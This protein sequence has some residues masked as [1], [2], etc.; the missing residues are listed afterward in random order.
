[1]F[2]KLKTFLEKEMRM[3]HI[4]QPVMIKTLLKSK[5]SS[6]VSK[7]AQELLSYDTSQKEYY[8]LVTKN[9]VG[10]VLTNKRKITEKDGTRY[11]LKGFEKLSNDQIRSLIEICNSKITEYID[12]RGERIWSHRHQSN[13]PVP[14]SVRYEVL[15]KAKGKCELCGISNKEKS[16]DIDHIIPRSKNGS[17]D[18]SNLQ[19]LCFTCNRQKRNLDNA[20]LRDLD[21]FYEYRES[22]CIFCDP[23]RKK[24]AENELSF[25]IKDNFPVT[26]DHHLII[27]KRHVSDYF[28][29]NQSEISLI[30]KMLFTVKQKLEKKDKSITGFNIGINSGKSAGQT[31][32]H[33]HIHLIPRRDGDT[34]NPKGGVRGVIPN[35]QNY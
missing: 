21:K 28:D 14:G 12:K 8:E 11:S 27:P 34:N 2:E 20:D 5:G 13:D 22:D 9:M 19:A 23:T 33:C 4:Y 35:K 29:L 10:R 6:D 26:K 25:A 18:I 31:I 16:L 24:V 15:K 7:I 1:M 3:S 30:N 17:N 32:F